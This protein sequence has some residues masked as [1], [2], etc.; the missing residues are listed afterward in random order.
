MTMLV[1]MIVLAVKDILISP[2][3]RDETT[4]IFATIASEKVI[5]D[6][7]TRIKSTSGLDGILGF[8]MEAA[9]WS[10]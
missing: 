4:G 2:V 5:K 1:V 10:T 8:E 3:M 7:A 6:G 9:G